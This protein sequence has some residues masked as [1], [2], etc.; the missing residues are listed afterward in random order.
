MPFQY[1]I[2][3]VTIHM[4]VQPCTEQSGQAFLKIVQGWRLVFYILAGLAGMTTVLLFIF[5]LEPRTAGRKVKLRGGAGLGGRG[6][7][8]IQSF[9]LLL[10][11]VYSG[12]RVRSML[13]S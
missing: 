8:S 13:G 12:I 1:R 2:V 10:R 9:A 4:C 5:G 7:T 3:Q 11:Q 6:R